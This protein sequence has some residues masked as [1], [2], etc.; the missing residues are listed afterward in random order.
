MR[1]LPVRKEILSLYEKYGV[2][3]DKV[4][5][6]DAFN[7]RVVAKVFEPVPKVPEY[8]FFNSVGNRF[9]Y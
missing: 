8:K 6:E 1:L 9:N 5:V 7:K 4:L 3:I 2:D